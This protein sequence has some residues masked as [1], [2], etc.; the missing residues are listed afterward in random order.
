MQDIQNIWFLKT[1]ENIW[2]FP[3]SIPNNAIG[4]SQS[5]E[6]LPEV[7]LYLLDPDEHPS[8]SLSKH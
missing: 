5:L 3:E 2:P 4:I 7:M 6:S 1:N 8:Y